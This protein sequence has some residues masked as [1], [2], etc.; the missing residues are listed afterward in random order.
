MFLSRLIRRTTNVVFVDIKTAWII[1]GIGHGHQDVTAEHTDKDLLLK[2]DD[3]K[4]TASAAVLPYTEI[5]KDNIGSF[6]FHGLESDFPVTA[7]IA[8]PRG[9]KQRTL[10]LGRYASER[11]EK[12]QCV[13]PTNVVSDLMNIVFRV[14]QLVWVSS[15]LSV[16]VTSLLVGL[17]LLLSIRLRK[18]EIETMSRIGCSRFSVVKI[19]GTEV[20]LMFAASIALSATL[21]LVTER[22]AAPW[23]QR[24]LF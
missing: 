21:A 3:D 2:T 20:F 24:W 9:D 22:V 16:T 18:P 5:T 10:L 11:K 12:A 7:V 17:V 14:E 1:E 4:V 23:V 8:N 19:I 13:K 6:H 15:L